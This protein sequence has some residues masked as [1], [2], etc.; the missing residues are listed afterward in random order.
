MSGYRLTA[1][2]DGEA[3]EVTFDGKPLV[4]RTG[5]SFA[6]TLLANGVRTVGRSFKY[7]RPR[8]IVGYG[9][10]EPNALLQLPEGTALATRLTARDGLAARAANCWPSASFDVASVLGAFGAL[11]PAG[12]YYKTFRGPRG[13]A[14]HLFEPAIRALAGTGR[15][16]ESASMRPGEKRFAHCD[17]LV[18][19]AGAA[20]LA[21]ARA[22]SMS[23]GARVWLIDGSAQ[24]GGALADHPLAEIDGRAS[25]H[26]ISETM[27][28]LRVRGVR[29][30][31]RT[32][33]LGRYDG[34]L[35]VAL[36]EGA[37]GRLWKIRAKS[38]VL[39]TGAFERPFVFADNDRPG[40]MLLS[41]V[42]SYAVRNGIAAGRNVVIVANHDAAYDDAV[43]LANTGVRVSALVDR[44]SAPDPTRMIAAIAVGIAIHT[45]H[46]AVAAL[47]TPVRGLRIG[48]SDGSGRTMDLPCDTIAMAGGWTPAVHLHSHAGGRLSFD[49]AQAAFL[50]T[51]PHDG[52]F[53]AGACNGQGALAEALA[54]GHR[55]GVAAAEASGFVCPDEGAPAAPVTGLANL[56]ARWETPG[57]RKAFVDVASD[58]TA[59]DLRLAVREG[60]E[61]VEL[62]KR[63]TT[64]GMSA[65]QGRFGNMNAIDVAAR[66]RDIAPAGVG[67]TTYRPPFVPV[68]FAALA[69]PGG[70][71]LRP[72]RATT[73]TA[74]HE[75]A[76]ATMYEAG[77]NWRRPGFYPRDGETLE[78]ATRRECRAVRTAAG[79]YDSSPL[80]KF[81]VAGR[82]AAA[83]LDFA[84][85]TRLSNLKIGRGRYAL[86]L[87]EDGRL[88]DDGIV[89]RTADDR[90]FVTTTT[91]NADACLQRFE[92]CRQVLQPALSV[93]VLPVTEKWADVVVCGPQARAVLADA[94]AR[95]PDDLPFMGIAEARIG[96][97]AVRVA[98]A[99]FTGELSFE[100]FIPANGA[101][102][103]WERLLAAGAPYG[104]VP[105]GSE[106]NHVLRIE[107]GFI[108]VG[109]EGDGI[110]DPDDL[111]L[112]FAVDAGK[113][114]FVG[115][116]AVLRNRADATGRP[117]LV[118]LLARD[119]GFVLPEGSAILRT[120]TARG[121]GYVTA[122]CHSDALGRSLA[123]ALVED[124]RALTGS[125]VTVS[126]P[127][128]VIGAHVVAPAFYDPTG[129]RQ[130]G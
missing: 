12:F 82:D 45:G 93:F 103:L 21:A 39:A 112:A 110:A 35:I 6:A 95:L 118:G 96:S 71:L 28:D 89:F 98:R 88:F 60:Y 125:D 78:D 53:S 84:Y 16:P 17:V 26:W 63:Y 4:A 111:G 18:V 27:R 117:Q 46:A 32:M 123:L 100:I 128:G 127:D 42:L 33:A 20:G 130:R 107:K 99:G 68:A 62:L 116:Q 30:L 85:A 124:G 25:A 50:P 120:D 92:Y 36:E 23:K 57:S 73:L 8:G 54:D 101:P 7:H 114:D 19:G 37:S 3:I 64:T 75:K 122:S 41:A 126:L 49:M 66:A 13:G 106:A 77:A 55:A 65:D 11:M 79:I 72:S 58:V 2:P 102:E 22:A 74:W 1:I 44:R 29:I 113:I 9:W 67:T 119:P 51:A 69:E 91:G 87:H 10:E 14:W 86:Q 48:S 81:E 129:V 109:H 121:R 56:L 15:L 59:A 83:F 61:S 40:V 5:E 43:A 34:G 80:G 70:K 97:Q 90:F 76:G 94:G 38:V 31:P 104:I 108:S 105:V 115:R 52:A 47:G 24:S